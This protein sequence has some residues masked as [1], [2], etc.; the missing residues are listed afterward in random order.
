MHIIDF[1]NTTICFHNEAKLHNIVIIEVP[2]MKY[3]VRG[4]LFPTNY[5]IKIILCPECK[6]KCDTYFMNNTITITR[7]AYVI[8]ETEEDNNKYN[9]LKQEGRE[10]L[11][12]VKKEDG[13]YYC[14][15][16]PDLKGGEYVF[17][18]YDI[19]DFF[20]L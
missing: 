18:Q 3:E 15:K 16:Y 1:T 12:F 7:P 13:L 17:C 14:D 11:I 8:Y 10:N 2:R 4:L 9:E 20:D 5:I 19:E 6:N